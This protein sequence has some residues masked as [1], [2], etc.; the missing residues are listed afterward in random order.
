MWALCMGRETETLF[1]LVMNDHENLCHDD[2]HDME[3]TRS[4]KAFS[5]TASVRIALLYDSK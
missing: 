2:V 5:M 3:K 1:R 4:G